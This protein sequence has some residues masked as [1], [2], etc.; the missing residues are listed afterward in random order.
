MNESNV[1]E[2]KAP[3][4]DALGKILKEAL[5]D[6]AIASALVPCRHQFSFH[7]INAFCL[8][9]RNKHHEKHHVQK[10]LKISLNEVFP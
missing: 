3:A 6:I 5:A 1:V 2:L 7:N 4:G 8:A 10:L 9:T